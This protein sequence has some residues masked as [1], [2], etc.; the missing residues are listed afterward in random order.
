[1]PWAASGSTQSKYHITKRILTDINDLGDNGI[2][3]RR[4]VIKRVTDFA[5]FDACYQDNRLKAQAPSLCC[6]NSS[7]ARS[8]TRLQNIRNEEQ[9]DARKQ[10]EQGRQPTGRSTGRAGG[11]L[12]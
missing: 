11:H 6:R 3:V 12:R 8:P 4:E 10:R 5:N 2:R 9:Q 7:T 1:M